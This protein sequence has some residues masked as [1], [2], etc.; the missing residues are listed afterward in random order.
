MPHRTQA[1]L[2]KAIEMA[3]NQDALACAIGITQARVSQILQEGKPIKAEYA[4][5]IDKFTNGEVSKYELRPDLFGAP[6][7]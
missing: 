4:V 2:K 7:Q 1:L 3:G 5:A 6:P